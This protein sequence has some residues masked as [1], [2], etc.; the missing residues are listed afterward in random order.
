M[1]K[2]FHRVVISQGKLS[3][4][5]PVRQYTTRLTGQAGAKWGGVVSR[6]DGI[7]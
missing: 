3:H 6:V 2:V 4:L 5:I 1:S 7:I